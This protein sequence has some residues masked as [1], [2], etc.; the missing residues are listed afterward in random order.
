[1]KIPTNISPEPSPSG[2]LKFEPSGG[3]MAI[4]YLVNYVSRWICV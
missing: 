4:R 2:T 3:K 1:L